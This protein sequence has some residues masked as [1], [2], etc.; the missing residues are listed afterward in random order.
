MAGGRQGFFCAARG[1]VARQDPRLQGLPPPRR[2]DDA[3]APAGQDSVGRRHRRQRPGDAARG[4]RPHRAA[5]PRHLD[6]H[7]SRLDAAAAARLH[8]ARRDLPRA[9]RARGAGRAERQAARRR[10]RGA[11]LRDSPLDR[12]AARRAGQG[13]RLRQPLGA[14]DG[15]RR[16]V[17][18]S[19]ADAAAGPVA[20]HLLLRP[21]RLAAGRA[22]GQAAQR[23]GR[24]RQGG[25]AS[26]DRAAARRAV[27]RRHGAGD[28]CRLRGGGGGGGL[29]AGG[30]G[31]APPEPRLDDLLLRPGGLAASRAARTA[32]LRPRGP[33][34]QGLDRGDAP[35]RR[36]NPR[37]DDPRNL[38][39]RRRGAR[40]ARLR[41]RRG[42]GQVQDPDGAV[43]PHG[44]AGA[45]RVRGSA[46]RAHRL[47]HGRHWPRGRVHPPRA[48]ALGRRRRGRVPRARQGP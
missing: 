11:L 10:G 15:R 8:G 38:R 12:R 5:R 45:L 35:P 25:G 21:R 48:R 47:P 23:A 26:H 4:V 28:V 43:G 17:A 24:A 42:G 31:D 6:V 1:G 14:P 41:P 36:A 16:R 34:N 20:G 30:A 13:G 33:P 37:G 3:R 22:T 44:A 46:G 27:A 2:A 39:R 7:P 19:A 29:L 18:R 32:A 40:S 9:E